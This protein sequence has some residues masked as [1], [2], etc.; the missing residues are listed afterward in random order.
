MIEAIGGNVCGG[1]GWRVELD[2]Q[3]TAE[4]DFARGVG[5]VG[6]AVEWGRRAHTRIA[7]RQW[8]VINV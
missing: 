3:S 8:L 4:W 7:G 1:L 5:W 6:Q 2:A